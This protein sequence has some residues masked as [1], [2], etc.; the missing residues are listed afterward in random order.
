M[1]RLFYATNN[2]DDAES[3]SDEVHKLGIDDH[4]FY[5]LS[6]DESGIK[7]HHLHGSSNI[8][9]TD[10]IAAKKRAKMMA[11]GALAIIIA[12]VALSTNALNSQLLWAIFAAIS[13]YVVISFILLITG[14]S[15]DGYFK[16]LINER[17][18]SGEVIIIID[19][20][21]AQSKKVERQLD[22]HDHAQFLADSSNL[23]SPIPD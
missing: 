18:D 13:A 9:K 4:H 12:A 20:E 21:K 5:V 22:T 16:S 2:L 6:R 19:V 17:L 15:F 14:G 8:D 10:I 3:I 11:S 23:A 7:S 1:K